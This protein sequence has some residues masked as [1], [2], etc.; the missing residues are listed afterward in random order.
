MAGTAKLQRNK[1]YG[2]I[3]RMGVGGVSGRSR[4]VPPEC[5]ADGQPQGPLSDCRAVKTLHHRTTRV[6]KVTASSVAAA[7]TIVAQLVGSTCWWIL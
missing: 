3:Q 5:P 4:C 2:R 7:F 1:D 6:L